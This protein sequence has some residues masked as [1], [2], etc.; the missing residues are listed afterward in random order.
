MTSTMSRPL[1]SLQ[2]KRHIGAIVF[3]R[4]D[5]LNALTPD[6]IVELGRLLAEAD[7]DPDI[8][9]LLLRG[10][11]RAFM[12]GGDL[13]YLQAAGDQAPAAARE[14][15]GAL[16]EA[17]CRLTHLSKPTIACIHGVA[18]GA[19]ISLMLACDLSIAAEN[20]RFVYAYDAI[21]SVPDSGLSQS[22]PRAVGLGNALRIA[23]LGEKL[24]ARQ[25]ESIGLVSMTVPAA[26]LTSAAM[27]I[28]ERLSASNRHALVRTRRLFREGFDRTL[29]DQLDSE[30]AGFSA[31]AESAAFRAAVDAFFA[32]RAKAK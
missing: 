10:E 32:K 27:A 14:T 22:L 8:H 19:G 20:A 3:D 24:D 6:M 11:G 18:A 15:I 7:S 29:E 17:V 12:A 21:A 25:A 1:V 31:C 16:N 4:P 23:F 26:D 9:C 2:R 13:D 30:K 28:A 5:A